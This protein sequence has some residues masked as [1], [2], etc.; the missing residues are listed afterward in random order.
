LKSAILPYRHRLLLLRRNSGPVAVLRRMRPGSLG[1]WVAVL[2]LTG[3]SVRGQTP[4]NNTAVPDP[5][6]VT[7]ILQVKLA[8]AKADYSRAQT[9]L[10]ASTNLPPGATA[11]DALE[12]RLALQSLVRT[13]QQHLDDLAGLSAVQQRHRDFTATARAWTGFPTPP[14]YS[15]LL[16]DEL[17][18]DQQTLTAKIKVLE[19]ARA[20]LDSFIADAKASLRETDG[21]LRLL[22]EQLEAAKD[23]AE[24][25]RLTWQRSVAQV[26]NH[27]AAAN[28]AARETQRRTTEAELVEFRERLALVQRQLAIVTPQVDFSQADLDQVL[29]ALDQRLRSLDHEYTRSEVAFEVQ[30]RALAEAR[31][32]LETALKAEPEAGTNAAA[33][34]ARVR[35]LQ[36]VVEV[37]N[38]QVETCIERLRVLR[39]LSSFASTERGLWQLRFTASQARDSATLQQ[40]YQRLDRLSGMV[41][42]AKPFFT[43]QVEAAA[44]QIAAETTR[45]QNQTTASADPALDRELL[46]SFQQR[47]EFFRRAL[48]SLEQ[49]E[50]LVDRWKESL[51]LDRR[52][53]PA[54]ERVRDLFSGAP[55]FVARL[56]NFELFA[57][58]DTITVDGQQITGRR[59]VTV[60]KISLAVLILVAG[61]W[62][63]GFIS[64]I[65]EPVVV[66]RL[67]IEPNQASL[68]R[69]W[70]RV[71]LVIG[72]VVFSLVSVKIPLTVFAFAGGALAI[73]VGFGTQTL[74]KNFISGIIILFERPFRVGDVLDVAGQRGTVTGIGIRSS[75]LALWDGTETLI[76][77]STLLENNLT[78]WTY[79]N[80]TVRFSVTVGI[81]YGSDTRRAAQLLGEI[82]DRHGLV[83]KEPKPQVLFTDF[84]DSALTFEL[85]YWVDVV[86][87]NAAQVASDL[88]HMIA[89]TFAE[90]GITIAFPQRDVHLDTTKPLQVQVVPPPA[91]PPAPAASAGNPPHVLPA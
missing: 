70:V 46:E 2:L 62:L 28:A 14:P 79:S 63:T 32:Q 81:A 43:Q 1:L 27:V 86:R 77:N 48:R 60:G 80:R 25:A 22:N 11:T 72:L 66:R 87:H 84:A 40:A 41:A 47:E 8:A 74:L 26:R 91:V 78:N 82:A 16:V 21:R 42:T 52:S 55:S 34:A 7:A 88:R 36:A 13:F 20:I 89:G 67:K 58:D 71:V 18:D 69:R 73:G 39:H 9:E 59:G 49:S 31:S 44:D 23:P 24:V 3:F 33:Q 75:V 56:W 85:R 38:V 37:R 76:P 10:G 64:R 19:T 15:V 90:H 29:G 51:D 35:H 12:Y 54:T 45:L 30:Q 5:A 50:R 4:T 68:I 61:Y 17:R 6:G 53:L 57:V 83:Q 65:V